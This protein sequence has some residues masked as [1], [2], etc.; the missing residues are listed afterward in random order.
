MRAFILFISLAPLVVM[1]FDLTERQR[2]DIESRIQAFSSVC[3]EGSACGGGLAIST[4]AVRSGE[5]VYDTACSTCHSA[6]L[7]GAPAVGDKIAWAGRITKGMDVLY[8]SGINGLAGS[9]MVAKGG[10][11]SCSDDDIKAAVDFMVAESQ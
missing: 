7:A 10:C 4:T 6:G 2:A 5:A 8:D 1:A 3:I 11:V 9:G